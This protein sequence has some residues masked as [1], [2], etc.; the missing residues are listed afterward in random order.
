MNMSLNM[1]FESVEGANDSRRKTD[2]QMV[3]S[4]VVGR[5]SSMN[6]I[7]KVSSEVMGMRSS[8]GHSSGTMNQKRMLSLSVKIE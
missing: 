2:D 1:I 8:A 7:E 6:P 4:R 5:S 3:R